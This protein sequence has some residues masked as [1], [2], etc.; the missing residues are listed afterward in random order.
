MKK[1]FNF[2]KNTILLCVGGGLVF[3]GL[4]SC[5]N[6]LK[7]ADV[8]KDLEEAVE[9]A[10]T[11]PITYF[12][13]VDKGSGEVTPSSVS[14]KKKLNFELVFK[15]E[16][17]WNFICWEVIDAE[18]GEVLPDVIKFENPQ[19]SQT[20]GYVINPREK[21]LIHP[22]CAQIPCVTNIFP[23]TAAPAN[24]P[25][26]IN[27]NIPMEEPETTSNSLFNFPNITITCNGLTVNYLFETPV[28]NS[29]KTELIIIPKSDPTTGVLLYNYIENELKV[30]SVELK[31]EFNDSIVTKSNGIETPLKEKKFSVFYVK[32]VDENKP[33]GTLFITRDSSVTFDNA[34]NFSEIKKFDQHKNLD[35][36]NDTD[37]ESP[38]EYAALVRQNIC[39]G[40]FYIYGSYY[41]NPMGI[42]S[43]V[44]KENMI[45]DK[46]GTPQTQPPQVLT[47]YDVN[48][49]NDNVKFKTINGHTYFI[50][51]H[52][53]KIHYY[54]EL[55]A[56][57]EGAISVDVYVNDYC[58]NSSENQNYTV[59]RQNLKDFYFLTSFQTARPAPSEWT[60]YD[61]Y[62]E[63]YKSFIKSMT[64][65]CNLNEII[66][67]NDVYYDVNFADD[68][69]ISANELAFFIEYPDSTH[70]Q[71]EVSAN[72]KEESYTSDD[73]PPKTFTH[74]ITFDFNDLT[75]WPGNS[76]NF[77]A[78]D[79]IG[80]E[81]K[82]PMVEFPSKEEQYIPSIS[83]EN[84]YETHQ[85][86]K[87]VDFYYYD[88]Y[89]INKLNRTDSSCVLVRQKDNQIQCA[90]QYKTTTSGYKEASP[91]PLSKG[92]TYG[93]MIDGIIM[94]S[95]YFALTENTIKK[96]KS[97]WIDTITWD[98]N[99]IN[100][101]NGYFTLDVRI[102][103]E[104]NDG[105]PDEDYDFIVCEL[106]G[107]TIIPGDTTRLVL[108]D[109]VWKTDLWQYGNYSNPAKLS[110]VGFKNN[111]ESVKSEKSIPQKKKNAADVTQ[112]LKNEYDSSVPF[113]FSSL[114]GNQIT[115]TIHDD[116]SGVAK[117]TFKIYGKTYEIKETDA[118][119]SDGLEK[120]ITIPLNEL[121]HS[122]T[123][124]TQL[125]YAIWDKAGNTEQGKTAVNGILSSKK[126]Y[127][128]ISE[129]D[130]NKFV[131]NEPV[132][133]YKCY[134]YTFNS[135]TNSFPVKCTDID[136]Y[137]SGVSY[138]TYADS[139]GIADS[140]M[141]ISA[142]NT[143]L[144]VFYGN[145]VTRSNSMENYTYITY[146]NPLYYYKGTAGNMANDFLLSNG[147]S[148]DSVLI[149]SDKPVYVHTLVTSVP[150]IECSVWDSAEWEFYKEEYNEKIISC[151]DSN[152]PKVYVIPTEKIAKG[153][154]YIVIAHYSNNNVKMSEIF[155][156]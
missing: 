84:S 150:L 76:I 71:K 112:E 2:L 82:V 141:G 113:I 119:T 91:K 144:K 73:D 55:N 111:I 39:D 18:T 89:S 25:I 128:K 146:S 74:K 86:E 54:D 52:T 149:G 115:L 154:H 117:G 50:I 16:D 51:K 120:S 88:S 24:T 75:I 63:Q 129:P 105:I 57:P 31:I 30:S 32:S 1:Q 93:I 78:R 87:V 138:N 127:I 108:E 14:V 15:P 145:K 80:N 101:H 100:N 99:V 79:F 56:E 107:K 4:V 126:Q 26:T 130:D 59:I 10:N 123:D 23:D 27:F 96:P 133:G 60:S 106:H 34:S 122:T 22:K 134:F 37:F 140:S 132:Y 46:Y 53:L 97:V 5:E 124:A 42:K 11:Q 44:V 61:T 29:D 152:E 62:M 3:L 20:K 8:R 6:F 48:S 109:K 118:A 81:Y 139:P 137:S 136:N 17:D 103:D 68:F 49:N 9:I 135:S 12:V 72:V 153:K 13:S 92:Y 83:E 70:N 90:V 155:T 95:S 43:V 143:Y 85:K 41:D 65:Y 151:S 77:I 58:Y 21:A 94:D 45:R 19:N 121:L 66:L 33:E 148:K 116:L 104:D 147:S 38:E 142:T 40:T 69:D 110:L 125:E 7:G 98:N 35:L 47:E 114:Q 36:Y 156:K 102:N 67:F 28:F 64:F 131:L